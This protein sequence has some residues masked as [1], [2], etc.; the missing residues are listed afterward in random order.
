MCHSAFPQQSQWCQL[1]W[2]FHSSSS[3]RAFT[4]SVPLPRNNPT[5]FFAQ[6]TPTKFSSL[7]LN[8]C[9]TPDQISVFYSFKASCT[10]ASM[11]LP[12][13]VTTSMRHILS[14]PAPVWGPT[15]PGRGI[16]KVQTYK[17]TEWE[18]KQW[19]LREVHNILEAGTDG[20][21]VS[22]SAEQ[23]SWTQSACRRRSQE[24][25]SFSYQNFIKPQKRGVPSASEGRQGTEKTNKASVAWLYSTLPRPSNCSSL[26]MKGQFSL[27]ESGWIR[28]HQVQ[29]GARASS[30]GIQGNSVE[31]PMVK[32]QAPS[33]IDSF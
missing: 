7:L 2:A 25:N 31:I 6:F 33:H 14:I 28:E 24:T 26:Q 8:V 12:P 11:N 30:S 29:E 4:G 32:A 27:L 3:L 21:L 23:K 20:Q 1:G 16:K 13:R 15:N 10:A 9:D 17:T 19:Q 22:D 18:R 5:F